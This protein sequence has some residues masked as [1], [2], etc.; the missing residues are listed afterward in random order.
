MV[1]LIGCPW[2]S[3]M[4]LV[5]GLVESDRVVVEGVKFEFQLFTKFA[6]LTEPKPVAKSYPAVVA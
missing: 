4:G 5:A 3:V 2:V 6:T 1:K